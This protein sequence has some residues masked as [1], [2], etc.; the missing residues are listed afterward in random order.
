MHS[1]NLIL[2]LALQVPLVAHASFLD[3]VQEGLDA[4]KTIVEAFTGIRDLWSGTESP[5]PM[6]SVRACQDL[7]SRIENLKAA[8]EDAG[9]RAEQACEG[10]GGSGGGGGTDGTSTELELVDPDAGGDPGT[11]DGRMWG[12]APHRDECERQRQR[13]EDLEIDIGKAQAEYGQ[14]SCD[15]HLGT[16]RR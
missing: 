9:E 5:K 10:R 11:F 16:H 4:V 6:G 8:R 2:L 1:R 7:Q 15:S 14:M 12:D 3:T 13:I